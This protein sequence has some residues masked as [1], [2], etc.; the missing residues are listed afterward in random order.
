MHSKFTF[1]FTERNIEF[2]N[3]EISNVVKS[4]YTKQL[5]S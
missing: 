5:E 4:G 2:V 1:R 3:G